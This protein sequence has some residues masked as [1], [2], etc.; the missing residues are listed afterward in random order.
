MVVILD[1]CSALVTSWGHALS[2]AAHGEPHPVQPHGGGL[3]GRLLR[4]H[5][6]TSGA[7]LGRRTKLG[8]GA[9][10]LQN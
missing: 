1:R 4:A 5:A 10:D 3:P 7:M 9:V 2:S 8:Q 6:R